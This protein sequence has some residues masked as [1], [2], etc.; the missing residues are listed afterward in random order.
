MGIKM[1]YSSGPSLLVPIQPLVSVCGLGTWAKLEQTLASLS[2]A[3]R[4]VLPR[5]ISSL[6]SNPKGVF[7]F[8]FFGFVVLV[9]ELRAYTLSHFTSSIL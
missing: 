7:F 6:L 1:M 3:I 9:F 8:S 5:I 4:P 2:P